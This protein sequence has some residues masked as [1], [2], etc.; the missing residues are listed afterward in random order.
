VHPNED[1]FHSIFNFIAIQSKASKFGTEVNFSNRARPDVMLING[2]KKL[3]MVIELK[4]N[5]TSAVALKQSFN[6]QSIVENKFGRKI[7]IVK[8][9]GINITAEKKVTIDIRY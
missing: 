5:K 7:E 9:L 4:Y 2:N 6:Y 1:L 8:Y 3:L